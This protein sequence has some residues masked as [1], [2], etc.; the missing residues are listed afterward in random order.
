MLTN[1]LETFDELIVLTV[2]NL[3]LI[4][5]FQEV[6]AD[7]RQQ[8]G[9]SMI[10]CILAIIFVNGFNW[11]Y[12]LILQMKKAV[13]KCQRRCRLKRQGRKRPLRKKANKSTQTSP[14][15]EE[16]PIED[17]SSERTARRDSVEAISVDL[18][19]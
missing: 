4:L 2:G 18:E 13:R 5:L 8:V 19:A 16:S 3:M 7:R 6:D 12:Q 1:L 10:M 9:K 17:S 15:S 11:L 14:P